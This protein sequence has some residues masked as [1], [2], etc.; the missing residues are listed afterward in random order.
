MHRVEKK[1]SDTIEWLDS[2]NQNK[3]VPGLERIAKL[4]NILEN[5]QKKMKLIIK[6]L[7]MKLERL[8]K[9]YIPL[10]TK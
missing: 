10:W 4:M 5:P 7:L 6:I 1:Y 8:L 2:L 3:I 9:D